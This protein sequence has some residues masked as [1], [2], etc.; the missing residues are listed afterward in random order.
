MLLV[1]LDGVDHQI[2]EVR[3]STASRGL[4]KRLDRRRRHASKT[5]ARVPESG[6]PGNEIA[7][8][9]RELLGEANEPVSAHPPSVEHMHCYTRLPMPARL[10]I[11]AIVAGFA[12]GLLLIA[13]GAPGLG[14]TLFIASFT[15]FCFSTSLSL[16]SQ[17]GI[18]TL[19]AIGFGLAPDSG[20]ESV[21]VVGRVFIAMLKMLIAPMI[22]LSITAGIAQMGEASALGRIG[23]RT[24]TLYLVTMALAVV[25]GLVLVNVADPG[26]AGTLRETTFF[27]EAVG[28]ATPALIRDLSLGEFLLKTVYQVLENPFA[29]LT[30]GRILPIVLFA[31]LLGLALLRVGERGHVLVQGIQGGYAAVMTIIHWFLRLAPV[32]IFALI[33]HLV[34]TIGFRELLEHLF[35]FSLVVIGGTLFHALVTLPIVARAVGGVGPAELFRGVREALVVA[36]STSS[37]AATLPVTTRCVEENLGVPQNVSSFVLPLGATV[38]MDGTAL[39][40]AIAALF[41]ANIYGIEL[42]LSDQIVIFLVAMVTAIGAPGIPSAGMVTMV[43]VLES[44]GLPAEAVG[45]LLTIDR[46]L[47]TFRTM[48]NVEGDAVVAVCVSRTL[49]SGPLRAGE[50]LGRARDS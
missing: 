38:N 35:V 42:G 39:Y 23:A 40:E 44:V 19:L 46:F 1:G 41:V 24:I 26:A 4:G 5:L 15:G 8:P 11:A 12:S 37:S 22:F 33:G 2:G 3:R 20:V 50:E 49:P 32:G 16:N 47:D 48:V 7:I 43:V 36:F 45:I 6:D 14:Y 31:I 21:Q 13:N 28:N 18:A 30:Q 34:A 9:R 17:I 10:R 29:S 27:T 25:T